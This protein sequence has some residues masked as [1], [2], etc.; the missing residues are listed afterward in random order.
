M[1][2][3]TLAYVC[4]YLSVSLFVCSVSLLRGKEEKDRAYFITCGGTAGTLG[5]MDLYVSFTAFFTGICDFFSQ[6]FCPDTL[7]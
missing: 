2:M 7:N 3:E 4:E 1:L 5:G 6:I